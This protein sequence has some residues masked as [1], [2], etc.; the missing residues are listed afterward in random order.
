MVARGSVSSIL[1]PSA[2]HTGGTPDLPRLDSRGSSPFQNFVPSKP[3]DE[4]PGT[5]RHNGLI[6]M[7]TE[8]LRTGHVARF[9]AE[10]RTIQRLT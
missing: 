2:I 9:Q 1:S 4:Q 8:F 6:D 3:Y 7:G 10:R 5:V